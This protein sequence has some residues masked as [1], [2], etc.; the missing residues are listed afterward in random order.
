M[1]APNNFRRSAITNVERAPKR[2]T[3]RR[4]AASRAQIDAIARDLRWTWV[5]DAVSL[6]H[7]LDPEAWA[8]SGHNPIRLL[9]SLSDAQLGVALDDPDVAARLERVTDDFERYR[10]H[11]ETWFAA[12]YPSE[13]LLVAYF[14]A[15]FSLA[16]CLPIFAGGLGAVAGEQLKSASALGVP[17]VGVGLLYH[18]TSHQWLDAE[19]RQQES[20]ETLRPAHLPIT[21]ARDRTGAPVEITI[22]FPG[23]EL[24]ARVWTARVG[25]SNLVLLDADIVGNSA[26]DRGV[27]RRLYASELDIRIRQEL[28]L[29]IGGA[30]AL[31][32]LGIEPQ[33]LHLNEGHAA[34]AALERVGR[35]HREGLTITQARLAARAGIL[36]TT[37][38]PVAAGHDYFPPDLAAR[39][40]GPVAA[41]LGLPLDEVL[42][43]GRHDPADPADTFCPT[44]LGLRL[45]AR[46]TGV[47]KL[48]GM[49]TRNQWRGLWPRVPEPEIPIG[50]VT[51]GIHFQSWIS[52]EMNELFNRYL[53]A[54]WRTTPG[55]PAMW[56]RIHAIDD[57]E[58]WAAHEHARSRMVHFARRWLH[59]QLERRR[60][61]PEQQAAVDDWLDPHALT[62][63]FVG[64][65][66]QYKRPTLFLSDPDRLARLLDDPDRPVQIVYAG[67]AHPKDSAGKQLLRD[68]ARFARDAGLSHR[69]VFLEDFDLAM[70]QHLVQGVDL[71]LNTP[72]RP[73]E[74]CGIGGMKNGANGGL[75]LSTIDGWWD[76][77][78]HAADPAHAPIGWSI[79]T[80][81][82]YD[83]VA[84]QDTDDV[85]SF[86]ELLE[87]DIVPAFYDRDVSGLPRRWIASMKESLSTLSHLW[88]SHRMV[89]EYTEQLYVPATRHAASMG[90]QRA[91]RARS[92]G[93][94]LDRDRAAW[95]A[96]TVRQIDARRSTETKDT[97]TVRVDV[98][99]GSLT[100]DD[101]TV[102]LW[103]D[104]GDGR[105]AV[106]PEPMRP[107]DSGDGVYHYVSTAPLHPGTVFAARVV[108][109]HEWLDEP[110]DTGLV[111]WSS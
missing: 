4:A 102:Q 62:I 110:L 5:P 97:V 72:R 41:Q 73:L 64:R 50:H 9:S 46:R 16:D 68:V 3:S 7:D 24:R 66:V 65:F 17:I 100:P 11:A 54:R 80:E 75:N 89:Q 95:P 74:A 6:F 82:P 78:W 35:L 30:R 98:E 29:G 37:H 99:L 58:L 47:S 42:A 69:L 14:S 90:E 25:R 85:N 28:L 84:D 38:T 36:F 91:A 57:D 31:A 79:G 76:E 40:L 111:A 20:W 39:Y 26:E 13:Q 18:E 8:A 55:D 48:H 60:A 106:S 107:V 23:R 70:D 22:P 87:R 83:D 51:N 96:V 77:A 32:R 81:D 71:W 105:A 108:P 86:Y 88:S 15:E 103:I 61:S 27:T 104:R 63:G 67:K 1:E 101:V 43:F 12:E 33:V 10:H 21:P 109:H 53:G 59:L 45:A 94:A 34:F 19:G 52:P 93:D 2:P 44:V 92:L 49:V 56:G